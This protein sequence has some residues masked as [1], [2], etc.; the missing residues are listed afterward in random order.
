[1]KVLVIVA[2]PDDEVLGCGGTI[3]K[4]VSAGDEVKIIAL[5]NG[6]GSREDASEESRND[7]LA[8]SC[9]VLGVINHKG[10][11][12]K[13]NELD[14]Y[15][16][17]EVIKKIEAEVL[18]FGADIVYTHS[19][20]DLNIDHQITHK[21]VMTCFRGLPAS[22]VKKIFGFETPS[23][24]EWQSIED[25]QFKPQHF[26]DID[27]FYSTKIKALKV[28]EREMREF[29]HPRSYDYIDALSKVRGAAVGLKRAEA[30]IVLRS[31]A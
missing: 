31:L 7:L 14:S 24:T 1:M 12:L 3:A 23:S 30:F 2:H 29:P 26:V 13:D 25:V 9:K 21:A 28:Y 18:G 19:F 17:L 4:H 10:F 20:S 16:L 27:S 22:S 11:N 6:E 5:A 15:T 8:E